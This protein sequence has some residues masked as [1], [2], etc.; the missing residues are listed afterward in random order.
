MIKDQD[1]KRHNLLTHVSVL[2][3]LWTLCFAG[4]NT[5][6]AADQK[7]F[8]LCYHSFLGN[9]RFDGDISLQELR[10]QM[11]YF[12][13]KGFH[14]VSY[15]DLVKGTVTGTQNLLLVIDDGNQSIYPA[16]KEIFKPRHIK[17]LLA[18]YPSVIGHKSYALTWEQ[19]AELSKDG[20]DIASHGYYHEL[21]NQK[22][23][24]KDKK[25]FLKEIYDSKET[26]EKKLNIK[27]TA[28][29]YPNGVRAD[30]T[31]KTLKE[32][33]YSYAFTINWGTMLSPLSLNKDP[34][35]LPRYMIWRDHGKENGR[36]ISGA[37]IKASAS[38][39]TPV[40]PVS[41]AQAAI[42]KNPAQPGHHS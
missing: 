23:Y 16:Y 37:I 22:F 6:Y 8:V 20:C 41:K 5:A 13:S 7:V 42:H 36:M 14:F 11:D 27:V 28:Y 29:V 9:K 10:S 15:S 18:I 26:L 32:A 34:Y 17:P 2:V 35:E 21:M 25:G 38:G 19:L 39:S 31:K 12:Q 1:M 24:D 3:L 33:G 30:V 40:A 4:W